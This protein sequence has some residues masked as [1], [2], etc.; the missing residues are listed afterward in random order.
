MKRKKSKEQVW[1]AN[2]DLVKHNLVIL[3]WGN[4]SGCDRDEGIVAI[5]PSGISYD[6]LNPDDIVIV[7]WEGKI[8]EGEMTPSSDTPVHLELYKAFKGISAVTHTH[9]EYATVF[10]QAGKEIPCLGTTHADYFPGS[11]P[12]TRKI[13]E[14]EVEEDY[15]VN[16]GRVIIERF[17]KLDPLEMPA[18]LVAGHG[19]FTWGKTPDEAVQNSVALEKVAQMAWGTLLLNQECERMPGYLLKKHHRRRH[20]PDAYY[21]QKKGSK[22]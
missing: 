13:S 11:V 14:K 18:V 19:P 6:E 10:A 21:G 20:G 12:V 22:E 7:D 15:E 17:A 5:K 3:T 1:R 8:V 9:S 4:V 16:T 2:M